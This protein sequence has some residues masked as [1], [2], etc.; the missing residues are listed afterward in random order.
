MR[1]GGMNYNINVSRKYSGRNSAASPVLSNSAL[2][3][4]NMMSAGGHDGAADQGDMAYGCG[5]KHYQQIHEWT[6]GYGGEQPMEYAASHQG[7]PV[8]DHQYMMGGYRP[9]ANPMVA[10]N[11]GVVY[12]DADGTYGYG[13]GA[14]RQTA[15]GEA[16]Y[17]FQGTVPCYS[18]STAGNGERILPS[19]SSRSR[20]CSAGAMGSARRV[21]EVPN[22]VDHHA[23]GDINSN[24]YHGYDAGALAS[25]HGGSMERTTDMYTTAAPSEEFGQG[26]SL[27]SSLS[28]YPYRYTDT[29]TDRGQENGTVTA[30]GDQ[31]YLAHGRGPYLG[32]TSPTENSSMGSCGNSSVGL[33]G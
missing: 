19:S 29:T 2:Y 26:N 7:V 1:S 15:A 18:E 13:N 12:M 32:S 27:R 23:L 10:R 30:M 11:T 4:H 17:G 6:S 33:H 21:S 9:G 22:G 25:C 5:P 14:G 31:Q 24:N 28:G 8:N 20:P 16:G 3:T